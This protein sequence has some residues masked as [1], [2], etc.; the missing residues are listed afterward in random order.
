MQPHPLWEAVTLLK[1]PL[2]KGVLSNDFLGVGENVFPSFRASINGIYNALTKDTI[3][4]LRKKANDSRLIA[5]LH[6]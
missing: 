3:H 5:K 1:C 6:E 2:G 4:Q